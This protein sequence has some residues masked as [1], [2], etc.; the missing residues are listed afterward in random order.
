MARPGAS[1]SCLTC[2]EVFFTLE[3]QRAHFK[4]DWHRLNVK[5]ALAGLP[6]LPEAACERLLADDASSLSG[7]GAR[8]AACVTG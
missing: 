6:A 8:L 3:E 7:S 4:M 1:K 5:R 2:G